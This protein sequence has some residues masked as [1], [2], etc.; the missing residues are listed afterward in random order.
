MYIGAA[1][2]WSFVVIISAAS[3]ALYVPVGRW[4]ITDGSIISTKDGW[5]L[6]GFGLLYTIVFYVIVLFFLAMERSLKF[7]IEIRGKGRKTGLHGSASS[8][9]SLAAVFQ[10]PN[11]RRLFEGVDSLNSKDALDVLRQSVDTRNLQFQLGGR[12]TNGW[13]VVKPIV[14]TSYELGPLAPLTSNAKDLQ[15]LR[16]GN[17]PLIYHMYVP[18]F[19]VSSTIIG[20]VFKFLILSS[21]SS[22]YL[23]A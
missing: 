11:T 9:A 10:D 21:K 6:S 14:Q 18:M 20:V 23:W 2:I 13:A 17:L 4:N 3:T 19:I 8:I 5:Y 16:Y 22:F 12:D 15:K 7:G 1:D